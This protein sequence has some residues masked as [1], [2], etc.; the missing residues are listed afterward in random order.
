MRPIS[1]G[2][3]P[4]DDNLHFY[5]T[6]WLLPPILLAALRALIALYIF[7]T[8][9]VIWAWYGTHNQEDYIGR[10]FS[11][12]TWLSYWGLGFYFLFSA[13]HT[14]CY[15]ITGSSALFKRWPRF[16]RA[17]HGLLYTTITTYPFLVTVIFWAI[18]F[19][20]FDSAFSTWHNIS[21]HA[22]NSVFALIEILL[23]TTPPHPWIAI[24]VILILLLLYLCVVY[25]TYHTQGF[26]TYSF[27]DP[28]H[29]T[30]SGLVTGYCFGILAA[31][32]VCFLFSRFL[33]WSRRKLVHGKINRAVRDPLR[34]HEESEFILE[35]DVQD[36]DEEQPQPQPQPQPQVE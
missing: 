19:D 7:T 18:L 6:S 17:L 27:L 10:T 15:V 30:K 1:F 2:V 13:L 28:H 31:I 20:G 14:T 16:M 9:I 34:A 24:P 29:G 11:Y 35:L 36:T 33:I 21:Q 5:E 25:I 22:L 32:L 3:D 8:I 26:Y 23:T 4:T 12:F